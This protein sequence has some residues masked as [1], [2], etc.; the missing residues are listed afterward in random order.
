[1]Q[2]R[3]INRSD[4]VRPQNAVP[5]GYQVHDPATEGVRRLPLSV[6]RRIAVKTLSQEMLK[7]MGTLSGGNQSFIGQ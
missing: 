3:A 4:K 2:T 5:K 6:P 1:M 7:E